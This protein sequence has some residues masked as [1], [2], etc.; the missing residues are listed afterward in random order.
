MGRCWGLLGLCS[1]ELV[2]VL[3]GFQDH[4]VV[5]VGRTMGGLCP[6]PGW[7]R[8]SSGDPPGPSSLDLGVLQRWR[9]HSPSPTGSRS[10]CFSSW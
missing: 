8:V 3:R 2:L 7:S 4:G 5:E 1:A 9:Q 10:C 6:V